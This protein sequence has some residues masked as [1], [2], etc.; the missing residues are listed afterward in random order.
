MGTA[1]PG[2]TAAVYGAGVAGLTV[3]HELARRGW[4][5][6][7]F[8]EN[9]EAGGF[10]RSA[11]CAGDGNAP[12]EYSWHGIGP[13]Y[14][15]VF[16][17]MK[18]IP[19]DAQGSVYERALSRPIDFGVAPDAGRAQFDD[20][21]VFPD[22]GRMFRMTRLDALR[23]GWLML[24]TWT[25]HRRSLED[26][27]LRNAAAEW[28]RVLSPRAAATW[29]ACFGPWVGSD[30]TRVSLHQAGLFFRRQLIT[31]PAH[32]HPADDEGPA[33]TQGARSGWLLLRGPSN[34]AWFDRWVEYLGSLGV[35]FRF[36]Q[37]LHRLD[38]QHG[39]IAAAELQCGQRVAADAHVL[40]VHPFA[41]AEVLRRTPR[42]AHLE[43]LRN[44]DP[45]VQDGPH[46]QVSFR[47]VFD[48]R[49]AWPRPRC[50]VV[51]ADSEFNITLFAQEQAW[52]DEVALGD[53]V[54]S[55]WTATACV[56]SVPGRVH[57]LPLERCTKAQ[58]IDEVKAQIL[59]SGALDALV[60]EGNGGRGLA[61]FPIRRIEVW[62]EWHFSPDGIVPRQPK[63]VNNSRNQRWLPGQA[64]PVDNLALAG[65]H[66]RTEA[67]VWSIEAAVESGRR[68]ARCFQPEVEV[69][70]QYRP[71]LLRALG[72]MDDVL[73]RAGGPHVLHVLAALG[74]VGLL[75]AAWRLGRGRGSRIHGGGRGVG[76][77]PLAVRRP[78]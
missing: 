18:Q 51:V 73:F 12:S 4:Q 24:K 44:F 34:E 2:R 78:G 33:W 9:P 14:H 46:T 50:A 77:P 57:G 31:R 36:G 56:S 7:V 22:V 5:V 19:F 45:L 13:W 20:T 75:L 29:A 67:D 28:G 16:D 63:W 70:P 43:E 52:A 3:A 59:Q 39:R 41:A 10:F 1:G 53:G 68:A 76:Q 35:Q 15:N 42:L 58:F 17:V 6:T 60:R 40:A 74:G 62:H 49:I 69:K 32:V 54:A 64:T 23:W 37:V 26:Y 30:W 65:A 47:L 66:T 55:L 61:S 8:E 71:R 25:A 21:G 72:A 38:F 48:R 27:A 11:R